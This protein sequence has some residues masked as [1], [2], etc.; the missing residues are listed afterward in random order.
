MIHLLRQA[1]TGQQINEMLEVHETYIKVAVDIER[2]ILA[3]GGEFHADCESV[4]IEHGSRKQDVWGADW[5]PS[6]RAVRYGALI[7][8]RP[9]INPS[10]EIQDRAVRQTVEAVVRALLHTP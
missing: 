10:M 9:K 6:E 7:N 5:I 4:L 3:G 2:K 8:I 1:A